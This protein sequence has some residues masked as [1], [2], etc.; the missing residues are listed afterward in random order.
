[1]T[2]RIASV[3]NLGRTLA[4][5]LAYSQIGAA[6]A[7]V[8]LRAVILADLAV[9]ATLDRDGRTPLDAARTSAS[10]PKGNP[11]LEVLTEFGA[12]T[13]EGVSLTARLMSDAE[14]K[15]VVLA[16]QDEMKAGKRFG[17][18][19]AAWAAQSNRQD[20]LREVA[21]FNEAEIEQADLNRW[22]KDAC[23]QSRSVVAD[24]LLT[25]GAEPNQPD[26]EG[27]S[28]LHAA[29]RKGHQGLVFALASHGAAVNG[30]D[31]F[32]STPLILAVQ[33]R[34]PAAV[35]VLLRA[36]AD[37]MI[38]NQDRQNA[39]TTSEQV[40]L[41]PPLLS[42]A[43]RVQSERVRT[44]QEVPSATPPRVVELSR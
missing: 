41:M 38:E 35:M 11:I 22:L 40:R 33:S 32:G 27:G 20:V 13:A 17:T 26:G 14:A 12:P 28:L 10:N 7:A 34:N 37:Q 39:I 43:A 5:Q 30:Q 16:W 18:E 29:A 19:A 8:D 44:G 31:S 4:H 3:D 42:L 36:G 24:A 1:M 21:Q 9:L 6:Q 2:D 15:D 23:T 25:L